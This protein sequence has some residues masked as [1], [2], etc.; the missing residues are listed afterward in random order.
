V[1]DFSLFHIV[2][3][4]PPTPPIQWVSGAIFPSPTPSSRS[5]INAH[6]CSSTILT[7][8]PSSRQTTKH[9]SG[10]DNVVA[11]ALSRVESVTAPPPYDVLAA[12]QD[13]DDEHRT[14][15]GSTTALGLEKLPIPAPRSPSTAT[16]LLGDLDLRSRSP[17]AASVP[18]RPQYFASGHQSN[19]IAGRAAFCVAR[20]A[21]GLPYLGA[22]LPVLPALQ[23]LPPYGNSIGRLHAAGNP[24]SARPHRL[25]WTASDVSRLHILPHC[26]RPLHPLARGYS[27]P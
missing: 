6:H 8:L 1:R 15:L 27:H 10:Q 11:D 22:C 21:E 25:G 17:T 4:G 12:T 19:G 26:S 24:L 13:G 5:G 7:L 14:L 2:L 3:S 16:R 9:I 23:S 20:R 18:V